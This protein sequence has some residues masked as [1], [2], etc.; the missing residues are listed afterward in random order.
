MAIIAKD[1][2]GGGDFEPMPSG[3]HV[4]IC[5]MVVDLGLQE[6]HS[7]KYGDKVKHQIYIRWQCPDERLS[8]TDKDG[9]ERE[10]PRVIGRVYT[11][12]LHENALLRGDLEN[13]RG[14]SFTRSELEGFDVAKLLG[15]ACM[16]NVTHD[17][18][19]GRTYA[20][21]SGLGRLPK[22]LTP[23]KPEN[24]LVLYDDDHPDA[25]DD[26]PE[27]LQNKIDSRVK[28]TTGPVNTGQDRSLEGELDDDIPF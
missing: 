1:S 11:L 21:V 19:D 10:G 24:S 15:A 3:N 14:K 23:P 28:D 18:R 22:G 7:A 8:W 26:L 9:N 2:G 25:Y 6:T 4:A 27:W 20:N 12:S 16:V 13:W 5:D 17:E